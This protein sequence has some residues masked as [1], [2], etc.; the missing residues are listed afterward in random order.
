[1]ANSK[2][3][4]VFF[5][6]PDLKTGWA[7][8]GT[9]VTATAAQ[10]NSAGSTS[11]ATAGTVTASKAVVVDSNKDIAAFRN[12]GLVNL[13]AGSSG[14]AGSV[15]IFPTT[16]SKGKVAIT[17]A[18]N[19]GNTTTAFTFGTM[20]AART[21]TVPDPGAAANVLLTTG[22]A[23]ATSATTAEITNAASDA[24]ASVSQV[25]TPASGSNGTQ[26]TFLNAAGSAVTGVRTMM[27]Y[28]STSAG[29]QASAV[30][31]LAVLTNGGLTELVTGKVALVT[32]TAAGLLGVTLT[33]SSASGYY[34]SFVLPSGKVIT[35]DVLTVN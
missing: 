26:F 25:S 22:T 21:I 9:A 17:A 30:D 15:D 34:L 8:E 29:V 28:I 23:T 35:S 12:V 7:I 32:T 19:T 3:V 5:E 2:P 24:V 31:G 14:V 11:G 16:A 27:A 18:D 20:A 1:M 6:D 10:L 4:G 13:D 33:E